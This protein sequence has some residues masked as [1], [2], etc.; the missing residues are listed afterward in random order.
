[1]I[2]QNIGV[3]WRDRKSIWNLYNKQVAYV[4]IEDGLSYYWQTGKAR[5]CTISTVVFNL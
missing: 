2:L 1:M 4:R 5:M 3:V